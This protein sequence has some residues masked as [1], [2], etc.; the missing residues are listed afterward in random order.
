MQPPQPHFDM[1]DDQAMTKKI[2]IRHEGM[3]IGGEIV[4]TGDV[5]EVCYPY[6]EEVVGTVPAG[7]AEHAARAFEKPP[8]TSR[9][10]VVT[11]AARFCVVRGN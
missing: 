5:I 11:N 6:T 10:S 2:D 8:T 4:F 9:R 7:K 1:K 3:R